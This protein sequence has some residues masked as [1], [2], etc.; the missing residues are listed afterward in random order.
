MLKGIIKGM[1]CATQWMRA[2]YGEGSHNF[3]P[4]EIG[5]WAHSLGEIRDD[6]TKEITLAPWWDEWECFYQ[7]KDLTKCY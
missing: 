3:G 5:V 2:D 6:K 4:N 1:P 7:K